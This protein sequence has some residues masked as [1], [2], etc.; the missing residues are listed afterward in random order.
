LLCLV[1][2][3]Y[4]T[5]LNFVRKYIKIAVDVLFALVECWC[6][7]LDSMLFCRILQAKY[8]SLMIGSWQHPFVSIA[9]RLTMRVVC[10]ELFYV[11]ETLWYAV[12]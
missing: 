1:N 5:D 10:M 2:Y 7:H 6:P 12:E 3:D 4:Y 9:E 8:N 11:A